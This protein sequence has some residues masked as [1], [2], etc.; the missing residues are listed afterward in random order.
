MLI[1]TDTGGRGVSQLMTI[2]DKGGSG[3]TGGGG[4]G[5]KRGSGGEGGVKKP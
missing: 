4:S 1:L 5:G 2:I 3:G